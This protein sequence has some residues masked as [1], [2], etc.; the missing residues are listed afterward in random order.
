MKAIRNE[1]TI[2]SYSVND[3]LT[4]N[5]VNA[6][7]EDRENRLWIGTSAGLNRLA[8]G[9]ITTYT[10][11]DGLA[12]NDVRAILQDRKGDLWM[13]TY[14]G[15]VNRLRDSRFAAFTTKEGLSDNKAWVIYEDKDADNVLWLG[16]ENGLNRLKEGRIS[17]FTVNEGLF[18][19]VVNSILEDDRGNLWISCNRGVYRVPKEELNAVAEGRISRVSYVSY[20]VSDGMLSSETNGENQ[21]AACKTR[22]GRLWFP[23]T[24]GIVAIEPGEITDNDL[25][26]PVVIEDIIMDNQTL[27]LNRPARL[28]PGRGNVIEFRYTANSLVAP[29]RVRFMYC[30]DGCDEDWKDAGDRRVAYYTNLQPGHYNF[31]VKACNNHGVWNQA[32]ASFAFYLAPHFYQTWPFYVL[33]GTFTVLTGYGLHRLRLG[34]VRKI[35]RL[36]KQH[37]LEKERARI[38]NEMH[39]DLGSSLTQIAL[40]SELANRDLERTDQA[41]EHIRKITGTTREVFRAMD[42]IVWA[43]NPKH[44]TLSSLIGYLSKFA[45]DY[46]RPADIRCRLDLP[47]QL[48]PHPLATDERHN[49]FLA[50]KEALNNV[51]KHSAASEVWLRVDV[52]GST[53]LITIEDN[54]RGFVVESARPDGN[55]LGSMRE[56][57]AAIDGEFRVESQPGQ[58]TK[59]QLLLKL[60]QTGQT[61]WN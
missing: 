9:K 7:Y 60:K 22:D 15:G 18:D 28:P 17:A 49:L 59:L 41:G 57:L 33:C 8:Q 43:V 44:D 35:E 1:K 6:L 14:G 32:G 16:T 42:E 25:A 31:R 61:L 40:L 56:R 58:G 46:L 47:E 51:V 11:K 24:D 2:R 34:V 19:N 37:A 20:G 36:E 13:A 27:D 12:H 4:H 38:A 55:G 52:S 10:T 23:T 39:D 48:P 5:Q 3:G 21:P 26:P 53:C 50:V 54:G 30:L 45:Q 29:E